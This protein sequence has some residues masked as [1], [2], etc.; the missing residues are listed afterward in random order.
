[1]ADTEKNQM[2]ILEPKNKEVVDGRKLNEMN[3][4]QN[5][6]GEKPL[7]RSKRTWPLG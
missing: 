3:R 5:G 1:M 6:K 4:M 7:G 2:Q